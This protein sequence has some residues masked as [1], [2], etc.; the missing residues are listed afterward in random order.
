MNV[1]S[2]IGG[3]A[4]AGALTLVNETVKRVDKDAPR[5]DL[6]GMNAAA[7]IM[8]GSSLKTPQFAQH[9]FPAALAGDLVSNT[10]YF[11]M[12]QGE[13][14]SKTLMRGA[15]LG[16]GA[17]VAAVTLAKPL[18]IDGQPKAQPVKTNTMT[19][20]YYLLGGLVAAAMINLIAKET[21]KE[22]LTP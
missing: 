11:A 22:K 6:L 14:K 1:V 16:L 13:T 15:L 19:I 9:L 18:G 12:A 17:G 3:L 5:L 4:G 8:K 10:L 20:A 21:L 7:K 2:V